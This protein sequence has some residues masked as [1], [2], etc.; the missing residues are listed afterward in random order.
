MNVDVTDGNNDV[1]D[2]SHDAIIMTGNSS[3]TAIAIQRQSVEEFEIY[4]SI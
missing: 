3:Y 2:L 1:T 4:E